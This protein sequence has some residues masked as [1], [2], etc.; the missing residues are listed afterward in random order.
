MTRAGVSDEE[1]RRPGWP[2]EGGGPS[3]QGPA[4]REGQG[5]LVSRLPRTK[6]SNTLLFKVPKR[7]K[8]MWGGEQRGKALFSC[9]LPHL[10]KVKNVSIETT[11]VCNFW[12][13]DFCTKHNLS[14]KGIKKFSAAF[15]TTTKS[16][17]MPS[18]WEGGAKAHAECL[19]LSF[20]PCDMGS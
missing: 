3:N 10:H 6:L 4:C 13:N 16:C 19:G 7:K 2:Q 15:P 11:R 14:E 20:P 1:A 5:H 18:A 17:S 9:L 12:N 8:C